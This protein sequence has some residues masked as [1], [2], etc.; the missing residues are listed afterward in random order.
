MANELTIG[1]SLAYDDGV[2]SD[3]IAVSG[4]TDSLSVATFNR[5]SGFTVSSSADTAI[6]LGA[7]S[8]PVWLM[9]RNLDANNFVTIK[10]GSSGTA[11][12]KVRAGK[13]ALIP[14]PPQA[15][16]PYAKADTA[17]VKCDFLIC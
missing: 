8:S 7:V 17:S 9:V 2:S 11:I 13:C 10:D 6:P 16:T 1:A 3:E 4:L 14:L 5:A 15:G 12:A